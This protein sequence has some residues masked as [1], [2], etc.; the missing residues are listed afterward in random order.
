MPIE[1]PIRE[2]ALSDLLQLLFLSRRTGRLI[3][4][5]GAGGHP[6]ILELDGGA[7]TGASG[8]APEGRIGGLLVGSGRATAEQVRT[9]A[10]LQ[11]DSPGRRIGEILVS[12]GAVRETELR[13]HLQ[14][15]IEETVFDLLRWTDGQVRFEEGPRPAPVS[16][17]VRLPTDGVLMEAVRRLDEWTEVTANLP[18]PDPLPVL[19]ADPGSGKVGPLLLE[20]LEWE[21]LAKTDGEHTLRWIARALGRSELEVARAVYRLVELGVVEIGARHG[22]EANTGGTAWE[23]QLR[24]IGQTLQSGEVDEADR[25]TSLLLA[26]R[27][28]VAA[29]HLLRGRILEARGDDAGAIHAMDRAIELDPLLPAAYLHLARV[30]V[31]SGDFERGKRALNTCLRLNDSSS[32][33]RALAARLSTALDELIAALEEAVE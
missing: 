14:L 23:E 7:L 13:R 19:A 24:E 6:V 18:D 16:I 32:E 9:A 27:P 29:I 17:E 31:R 33:H 25:Q 11:R 28:A 10:R 8:G 3:A 20:P 30:A 1:G 12:L 26:S 22:G 15:Q 21:V 4:N 2:L 5:D